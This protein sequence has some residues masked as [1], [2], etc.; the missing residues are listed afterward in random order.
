[1]PSTQVRSEL[2]LDPFTRSKNNIYRWGLL[3]SCKTAYRPPWGGAAPL[4]CFC[5]RQML[6]RAAVSH[7]LYAKPYTVAMLLHMQKLQ[8]CQTAQTL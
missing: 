2:A 8:A 4:L 7:L 3:L 5:V 1:M 6:L